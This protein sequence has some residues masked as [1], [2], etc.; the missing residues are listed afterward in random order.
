MSVKPSRRKI[1][2]DPTDV[3]V[4]GAGLAGL[5]AA[6][7]VQRAGKTVRVI[8]ARDRVGGRT[9]SQ[10]IGTATFDLG[11]QWLGPTQERVARLVA[12]AGIRTFPRLS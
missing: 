11:G 4:V 5:Q 3:I 9:L 8:E 10:D 12:Q 1:K 2:L 6:V 7:Q